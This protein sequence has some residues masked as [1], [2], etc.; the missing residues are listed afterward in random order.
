MDEVPSGAVS[1][2][3]IYLASCLA[4]NGIQG[5]KFYTGKTCACN[6]REEAL[7]AMLRNLR[8]EHIVSSGAA[9]DYKD[10]LQGGEVGQSRDSTSDSIQ[11]ALFGHLKKK[12]FVFGNALQ[13]CYVIAA[14]LVFI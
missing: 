4:G 2:E 12:F 14:G 11:G 9:W 5:T 10:I 8:Q 3:I 7:V 13:L 6:S 1:K